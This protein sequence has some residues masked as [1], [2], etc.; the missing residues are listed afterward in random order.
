MRIAITAAVTVGLF[1]SAC[2]SGDGGS[3]PPS[4]DQGTVADLVMTAAGEQGLQLD[5]DCVDRNVAELTDEDA[6]ALADAGLDGDADISDAGGAIGEKIFS[7]C[8]DASSY[9]DALVG[10]F[11]EDDPTL[12]VACLES[13]LEGK[14]VDEIDDELL[15]TALGCT[16]EG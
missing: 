13:A 9:L 5:R 2:A 15:D 14:T 4:G 12:D 3:S 1:L 11:G 7:E 16:K 8:L 6:G 10:S